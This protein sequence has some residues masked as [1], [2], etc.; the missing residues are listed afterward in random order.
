VKKGEFRSRLGVSGV[1]LTFL[2]VSIVL[3]SV[4]FVNYLSHPTQTSVDARADSTTYAPSLLNEYRLD[5]RI[6]ATRSKSLLSLKGCD[7]RDGPVSSFLY[8]PSDII[9]FGT[10]H[11]PIY[12]DD[13]TDFET[14]GWPGDGSIGSP[15]VIASLEI[16]ATTGVPAINITGTSVYFIIQDCW[17]TSNSISIIELNTVLHALIK[18]NTVIGSER[19]VAAFHSTDMIIEENLFNSFGW[20]GAYLEDCSQSSLRNNNCTVCES[21]LDVEQSDHILIE[22]NYATGCLDGIDVYFD[23]EYVTVFNNTATNN[24]VGIGFYLDCTNNLIDSNN[25][26]SNLFAGIYI[27]KCDSNDVLNN[28]GRG[29]D[30]DIYLLN[31]TLHNI[32][33]NDCGEGTDLTSVGSIALH[34]SNNSEIT[35]N[36]IESSF[37]TIEIADGSSY[38]EIRDNN[39]TLFTAGVVVW[40]NANFNS[41]LNNT[42]NGMYSAQVGIYVT[43]SD[44]C[45]VVLNQCNQSGINIVLQEANYTDVSNNICYESID[46]SLAIWSSYFINVEGNILIIGVTG[47]EVLDSACITVNDNTCYNFTL[48]PTTGIHLDTVYNGT[49]EGNDI[50]YNTIGIDAAEFDGV[51]THNTIEEN[52][53][54][55]LFITGSTDLNVTWN[56]FEDNG[57]NADDSGLHTYFDYN[58]WSNYTGVDANAD[59]IGDTWH[60][61]DGTAHNNDTH[62][63]VFYPTLPSWMAN[64]TNQKLEYGDDF[65][66]MLDIVIPSKAAPVS[67]WWIS[68]SHFV[69][70]TGVITNDTALGLGEYHI[71]VRVYNLYGFYLKG[72]FT[73]TVADTIAPVITGPED[74]SF[75]SDSTGYHIIWSAIDRGPTSYSVKLD[76]IIIQSGAWNSS[77][78]EI[79]IFCNNL[80]VGLHNFTIT[81]TDIG[82]NSASDTVIVTVTL[83]PGQIFGP[84][85]GLVIGGAAIVAIIVVLYLAKKR[86]P[87]K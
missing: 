13:N 29:N 86:T 40:V 19:G 81:Y 61:I 45:E 80:D 16:N 11:A 1:L 12:I 66:Y 30:A 27:Q 60:H 69:I 4:P 39:C 35:K 72:I 84:V 57:L 79:W 6:R 46:M 21:G 78:E 53:I 9:P 76:D 62:P 36:H 71:E 85:V 25:C 7:A 43:G 64:P 37:I 87:S 70:N 59:G 10:P 42:C 23:C 28:F 24:E 33:G 83:S 77:S 65:L 34:N 44:H 5:S 20:A 82:G 22:N 38:N 32:S 74:F 2:L 51:I 8:V 52:T 55:G 48:G 17:L 68:D 14:Q 50:R 49:I 58:Y 67:E 31:C 18:N 54:C 63:L 3:I 41:I 75:P 15:Y 56:I 73:V 26:T 47:I